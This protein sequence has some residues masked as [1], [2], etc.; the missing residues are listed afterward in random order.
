MG[1]LPVRRQGGSQ[2]LDVVAY[3]LDEVFTFR[4]LFHFLYDRGTDDYAVS[5]P[6]YLADLLR[7]GDAEP[8]ADWLI[9][10]P[11]YQADARD[12]F[13]WKHSARAGNSGKRDVIYKT[14]RLL[15]DQ[16]DTARRARRAQEEY[17]RNTRL[18]CRG[19]QFIR[20]IRRQ[21][22]DNHAVDPVP[23]AIRNELLDAVFQ[24][25]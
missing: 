22:G 15:R 4:A 19:R 24:D 12:E 16:S 6:G 2:F 21:V 23:Y 1:S 11:L 8:D 25:C 9:G 7:T 3:A 10:V 18:L 20:L 14:F 17:R 5:G 13:F